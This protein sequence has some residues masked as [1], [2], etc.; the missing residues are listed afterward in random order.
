MEGLN[1]LK[2]TVDFNFVM[3]EDF[4]VVIPRKS[5]K[6]QGKVSLN[7]F[8]L[9]GSLAATSNEKAALMDQAGFNE[10]FDEILYT[11]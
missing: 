5:E 6:Y 3:G 9:I 10:I 7:G 2:D 1:S 11:K 4:L 8:A